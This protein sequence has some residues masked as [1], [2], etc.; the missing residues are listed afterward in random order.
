MFVKKRFNNR[1]KHIKKVYRRFFFKKKR[2]KIRQRRKASLLTVN[3][4]YRRF[5]R[6]FLKNLKYRRYSKLFLKKRYF[7]LKKYKNWATKASR[8]LIILSKKKSKTKR[9]KKKVAITIK[10]IKT[11][12][13][14]FYS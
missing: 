3:R 5:G 7:F 10:K 1:K 6:I 14:S 8:L 11:T 13:R 2:I 12:L 9:K 4:H